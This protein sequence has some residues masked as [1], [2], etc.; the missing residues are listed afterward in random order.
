MQSE[1]KKHIKTD[2][3]IRELT[4]RDRNKRSQLAEHKNATK[5]ITIS[6]GKPIEKPVPGM[7]RSSSSQQT[8]K[9]MPKFSL[10]IPKRRTK[11]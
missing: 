10:P 11:F 8:K 5:L 4:G 2:K 9:E 1:T 6:N 7:I 3:N